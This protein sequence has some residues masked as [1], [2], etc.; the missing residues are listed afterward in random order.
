MTVAIYQTLDRG[1][2]W[3][4]VFISAANQGDTNLPAAGIKSRLSFIDPSQGFIGLLDRQND[5]ALYHSTDAG[6]NWAKQPLQLPTGMTSFTASVQPAVFLPKNIN[7]GFL[8]VDFTPAGGA[9]RI[10]VFYITH[11][12]GMSW[13]LGGQIPDGTTLYFFDAQ[14]GWAWGGQS[15]YKTSDGAQTWTP[16]PVPFS[17]SERARLLDF[18][19][20]NSGWLVT[21]D[22]HN[23]LQ[24]YRTS[25][26]G[27]TWTVLVP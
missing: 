25:D 20:A 5:P 23:H 4:Q 16:L 11:D 14:T 15:L 24:T 18:I 22:D 1:A 27:A 3:E 21:A 10:R 7:D 9:A 19:D 8:P 13:L 12:A 17:R 6:R 2:T 26:G